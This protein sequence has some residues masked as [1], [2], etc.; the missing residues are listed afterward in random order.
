VD[1]LAGTYVEDT[2]ACVAVSY[3]SEGELPRGALIH[4]EHHHAVTPEYLV[5]FALLYVPYEMVAFAP[6]HTL[7]PCGYPAALATAPLLCQP[8]SSSGADCHLR[9]HR[10]QQ[11]SVN[12]N[13]GGDIPGDDAHANDERSVAR[14]N[15]LTNVRV[16]G[17]ASSHR[18]GL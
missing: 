17:V 11:T 14:P 10:Q 6:R 9:S 15:E 1:E 13:H 2:F 5:I 18:L 12:E 7:V 16:V 8:A 4:L 3:S